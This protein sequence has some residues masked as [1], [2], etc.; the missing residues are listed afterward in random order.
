MMVVLIILISLI[1][2][3]S[4]PL[5]YQISYNSKNISSGLKVVLKTL[6]G[7]INYKIDL[8][9][10]KEKFDDKA[11]IRYKID[12][13]DIEDTINNKEKLGIEKYKRLIINFKATY[14]KYKNIIKYFIRKGSIKEL[15]FNTEYDFEDAAVTGVI[16]GILYSIQPS[17][18]LWI[19]KYAKIE[20]CQF[21]INPLFKQKNIIH[22]N[23]SCIIQFKLGHIIYG[24][25][26]HLILYKRW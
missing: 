11:E 9:D 19:F 3:Y 23:F 15:K 26:K 18:L 20:N 16:T 21:N 4:M 17:I 5:Q 2:I 6:Y 13:E 14:M 1:F 22:I 10:L 24:S 8:A 12:L 25:I 7:L